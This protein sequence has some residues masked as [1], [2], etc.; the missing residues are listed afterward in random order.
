MTIICGSPM[1]VSGLLSDPVGRR[2]NDGIRKIPKTSP[3]IKARTSRKQRDETVT[4]KGPRTIILRY[5]SGQFHQIPAD[6]R[7]SIRWVAFRRDGR[8]GMA[9]G[10]KGLVLNFN[11]VTFGQQNSPSQENL[12]CASYNTAGEVIIVGNHGTILYSKDGELTPIKEDT[13]DNLRR[14]SWS[15]DG[16]AAI[17]V[18]NN[19]TALSWRGGKIK[20]VSGAI[21]NLRS[22]SWHPEDHEA[23]ISGNYFGTSMVPC[24][25]LYSYELASERMRPLKTTDKIDILGIEWRPDGEYALAVG[26]ELVWHE[27]R[28]LRW[29][30]SE[31]EEVRFPESG[32]YPTTIAWAPQDDLALIGTGSPHLPGRD[33]GRVLE[34]REGG[35]RRLYSGTYRITCIAWNPMEDYAVIVGQKAARTFTT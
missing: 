10:N 16:S 30:N 13:K 2:T 21:N 29:T 15:P 14:V 35:I 12:R 19:G 25:T 11:G 20:E 32:L 6:P 1:M 18:G 7:H 26:Y 24:P 3:K 23:L 27:P 4:T 33:E 9:V 8:S 17:L 5:H 28:L 22:V 31:L 34:Y